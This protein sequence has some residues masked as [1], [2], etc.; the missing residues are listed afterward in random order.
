MTHIPYH[1]LQQDG[2]VAVD[3]HDVLAEV[4]ASAA[5]P[6]GLQSTDIWMNAVELTPSMRVLEVGCGTGRT[7]LELRKRYGCQVTGVD[8]RATMIKK[9]QRRSKLMGIEAEWKVASAEHLPFMDESFDLIVT[10]SVNVFVRADRAVRE[11]YRV[12]KRPGIYVDVEMMVMGPVSEE[13]KDATRTVYGVVH[14]PDYAGW[15]HLFKG[16]GFESVEV[17]TTQPVR[18]Q[19]ALDS[20]DDEEIDVSTP[21]ALRDPDVISILTANARWMEMNHR[22]LGFGIF[23]CQK[24]AQ[25]LV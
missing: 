15:K 16:A 8:V 13:W 24:T 3:Y 12:L 17:L 25:A 1:G 18:P 19:D 2:G 6:G 21:G 11:Y 14:V 23:L 5:H 4:G 9:A 10:E 7:A 20:A 22:N